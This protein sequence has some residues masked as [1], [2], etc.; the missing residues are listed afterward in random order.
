MKCPVCKNIM[1]V[2]EHDKV[3]LDHCVNCQG[4]WFDAGELELFL[5]TKK[6]E[7]PHLYPAYFTTA[8]EA[9]TSEKKRKCPICGKKMRKVTIGEKPKVLID[10]CPKGDGLWFDG[11]EVDQLI[12]Q[13]S[14]KPAQTS[15]SHGQVTS[16]IRR[17][18][19]SR[20]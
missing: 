19:K 5:D 7:D 16:F 17:V 14:D 6:L 11:G 10:A 3:E 15:D 18:F 12:S 2:V 13:L 20:K 8:P 1:I 9:K 4:A